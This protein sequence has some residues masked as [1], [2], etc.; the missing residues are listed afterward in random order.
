LRPEIQYV[1]VRAAADG[2][3]RDL[4]SRVRD[5]CIELAR[6]H[7]L[8]GAQALQRNASGAEQSS[9]VEVE[10][11]CVSLVEMGT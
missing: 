8:E 5:L 4:C 2:Q 11:I 6:R 10:E 1:L 7:E 3:Y 9:A